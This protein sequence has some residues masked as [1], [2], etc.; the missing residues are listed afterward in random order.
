[1]SKS[2]LCA[3]DMNRPEAEV[4]VLETAARLAALDGARL[5]V[6]TVLP[7]YGSS[8]V[9]SFFQQ[10]FHEKAVAQ[11]KE[12]LHRFTA[13]TIGEEMDAGVRHLVSTGKAYEHILD[14]AKKADSDLIVIGAH[15]PELQDYLL[16]PN[17]AR[18]VRHAKCSV[19]VVR[20]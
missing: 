1:M 16:G 14:A 5:D 4:P 9:G 20:T 11:T 13:E 19:Y 7:D 2:I 17:A 15:Q 6:I 10:G 18:V 3:I 12:A 8:L